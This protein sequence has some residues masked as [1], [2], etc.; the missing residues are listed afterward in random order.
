M[1]DDDQRDVLTLCECIAE[2]WSARRYD[3][4]ETCLE[5]ALAIVGDDD[6]LDLDEQHPAD[7]RP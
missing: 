5:D 6:F 7:G 2:M 1:R 4:A 3:L